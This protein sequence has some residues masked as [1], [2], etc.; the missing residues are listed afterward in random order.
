MDLNKLWAVRRSVVAD[1]LNEHQQ[2]E[3]KEQ[4]KSES[5]SKEHQD[6][7]G[8]RL[9]ESPAENRT[10]VFVGTH[11]TKWPVTSDTSIREK[12]IA[13]RKEQ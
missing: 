8:I 1:D 11:D 9:G 5:E 6:E 12:D 7:D 4:A 3:S 10:Y 2:P 13:R